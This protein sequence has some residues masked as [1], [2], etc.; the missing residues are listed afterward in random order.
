M[1]P[2]ISDTTILILVCLAALTLVCLPILLIIYLARRYPEKRRQTDPEQQALP[3][4]G[5]RLLLTFG[6]VGPSIVPIIRELSPGE[7][8]YG[9][10]LEG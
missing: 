9:I 4:P 2:H 3:S 10:E 7:P 1:S 6:I 8:A 5:P